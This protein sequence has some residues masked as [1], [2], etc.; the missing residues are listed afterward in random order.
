LK[1]A[2]FREPIISVWVDGNYYPTVAEMRRS[3]S[4]Y[5]L[6]ISGVSTLSEE[7]KSRI[8]SQK[9][10]CSILRAGSHFVVGIFEDKSMAEAIAADLR[11]LSKEIVV[12][13]VKK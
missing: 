11:S 10:D 7:M 9:S 4:Q 2:G 13:I 5:S 1:K 8:L 3:E 12:E 6:E